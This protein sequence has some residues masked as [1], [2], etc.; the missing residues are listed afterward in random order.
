MLVSI[1]IYLIARKFDLVSS[2]PEIVVDEAA[3]RAVPDMLSEP[4]MVSLLS[5]LFIFLSF[6][7][8][9]SLKKHLKIRNMLSTLVS[10][11]I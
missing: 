5:V 2:C 8:S 9:K 10:R 11:R 1:F 6:L 4:F 7:L 3:L